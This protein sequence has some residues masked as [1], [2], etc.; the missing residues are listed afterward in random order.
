MSGKWIFVIAFLA[1]LGGL[2]LGLGQGVRLA[3]A[4]NA[5]RQVSAPAEPSQ[6]NE[7]LKQEIR[8]L[9]EARDALRECAELHKDK[10]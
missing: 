3:D 6:S 5:E 9:E 7:R 10:S 8:L 4:D 2:M 1:W